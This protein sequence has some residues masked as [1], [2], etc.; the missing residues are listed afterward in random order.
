M[1]SPARSHRGE[2][3]LVLLEAPGSH[4]ELAAL[5][6]PTQEARE[7]SLVLGG[8]GDRRGE[9]GTN[10][11]SSGKRKFSDKAEQVLS[12]SPPARHASKW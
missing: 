2:W 7:L 1:C 5:S 4:V 11:S 6:Y 12:V 10:R 9:V 8:A 3:S